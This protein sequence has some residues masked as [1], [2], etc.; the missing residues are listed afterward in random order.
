MFKNLKVVYRLILGYG[1]MMIL[2]AIA[3]YVSFS[4]LAAFNHAVQE[5]IEIDVK[6]APQ[7]QLA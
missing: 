3:L 6:Q 2:F 1:L 5:V 4:S 7:D